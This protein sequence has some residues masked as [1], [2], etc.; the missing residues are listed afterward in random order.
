MKIGGI[1]IVTGLALCGRAIFRGAV[2]VELAL[3][4]AVLIAVGVYLI[5]TSNN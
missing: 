2:T 4:C 1:L 3:I 5:K